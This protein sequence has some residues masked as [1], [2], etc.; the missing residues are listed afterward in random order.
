M[1]VYVKWSVIDGKLDGIPMLY[2]NHKKNCEEVLVNLRNCLLEL[3]I[4]DDSSFNIE[5][6]RGKVTDRTQN[7]L[8][9]EELEKLNQ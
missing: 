8:F 4:S 5:M 3:G 6:L 1:A 7:N 2:E 9:K